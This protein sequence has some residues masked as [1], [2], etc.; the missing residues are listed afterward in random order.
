[1]Q[2]ERSQAHVVDSLNSLSV[3]IARA[4]DHNASVE[5]WDRYRA[6][7][8]NVFTRRLYTM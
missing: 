8:R 7:E 1:M 2:A 5:L 6:G 3:D 4:I